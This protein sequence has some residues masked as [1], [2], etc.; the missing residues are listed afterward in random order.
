LTF[1]EQK[2]LA[3][4]LAREQGQRPELEDEGGG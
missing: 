2:I 1:R 4:V 3:S